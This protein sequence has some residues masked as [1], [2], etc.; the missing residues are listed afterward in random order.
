MGRWFPKLFTIP[1]FWDA[2]DDAS[3]M[4]TAVSIHHMAH[5][6]ARTVPADCSMHVELPPTPHCR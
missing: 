6:D 5:V 3:A 2:D 4:Y 1:S